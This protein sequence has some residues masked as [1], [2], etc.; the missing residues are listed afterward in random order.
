MANARCIRVTAC[1]QQRAARRV[2]RDLCEADARQMTRGERAPYGVGW[3]R[4]GHSAPE[5]RAALAKSWKTATLAFATCWLYPLF[6]PVTRPRPDRT[7]TL[8]R[9]EQGNAKGGV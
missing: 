3:E 9:C 2:V 8:V 7:G 1:A 5:V 6:S 4:D